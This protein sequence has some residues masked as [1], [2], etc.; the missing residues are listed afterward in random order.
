MPEPQFDGVI[1]AASN[2]S[3]EQG[4][5]LFCMFYEDFPQFFNGGGEPLV[6]ESVMRQFIID[7]NA[8]ITPDRWF[9]TWRFACG[10]YVAHRASMYL[11]TFRE[12]SNSPSEAADTGAR[13][14]IVKRAT[15]GDSSVEYDTGSVI[16]STEAWGDLNATSYGQQLASMARIAGLGGSYV[17]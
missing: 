15:L 12:F 3:R 6:P 4:E 17:L 2:I 10:L 9:E 11:K 1:A 13:T 16:G 14:G 8:R 5:Y 7:A